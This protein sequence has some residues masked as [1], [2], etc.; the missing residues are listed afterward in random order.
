M[1]QLTIRLRDIWLLAILN[2]YLDIPLLIG[3][4][5]VIPGIV[6]IALLLFAFAIYR[7][8]VRKVDLIIL[9]IITTVTISGMIINIGIVKTVSYTIKILQFITAVLT[10][11]LLYKITIRVDH[12]FQRRIYGII[13]LIMVAGA[14]LEVNGS[15]VKDL[16]DAFR[17]YF[18]ENTPWGFYETDG[19]DIG[20]VGF[21]RPE[22]FTSETSLYALGYLIFSTCYTLLEDRRFNL[23]LIL[24][25]NIIHISFSG[26]P[27]SVLTLITWIAIFFYKRELK[28][29]QLLIILG[30]FIVIAPLFSRQIIE[31]FVSRLIEETT[32]TQSSF[33]SR[34][35]VPYVYTIP[36][37]LTHNFLIGIGFA[38]RDVLIAEGSY[39]MYTDDSQYILGTNAF[40]RFFAYF[41]AGGGLLI[42]FCLRQFFKMYLLNSTLLLFFIWFVLSQSIGALETPRYWS[43]CFLIA[44]VLTARSRYEQCHAHLYP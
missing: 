36:N 38:G 5:I 3:E 42:L 29:Q 31:V 17:R 10:G 19:R 23:Y 4:N 37:S 7:L 43:Y 24:L 33:Y 6:V 41:G 32:Q 9:G 16:S 40:A 30:I 20:S 12:V 25:L 8:K 22:F 26:S 27:V 44:G 11:L 39:S 15:V 28:P 13:S 18:F 1:N 34:I 21:D 2:V 14:I 35:Y